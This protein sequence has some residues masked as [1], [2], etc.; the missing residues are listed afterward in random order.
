MSKY[1]FFTPGKTGFVQEL[2]LRKGLEQQCSVEFDL[3]FI[4]GFELTKPTGSYFPLIISIN[5]QEGNQ[6]F[7]MISYCSFTMDSNQNVSGVRVLKQTVLI[8]GLPY[9]IKTIYGMAEDHEAVEGEE[10]VDVKD[11]GETK[12]CLVCL[13]A[14]KDTVIMPCGHLCVCGDCGK[15]LIKAK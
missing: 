1:R 8:N 11:D 5:Y 12:E 4:V 15:G 2:K 7:A 14:D 13:D 3:N 9:E 6:P 10:K